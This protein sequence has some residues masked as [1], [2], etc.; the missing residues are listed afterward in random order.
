MPTS[1]IL[2]R[3]HKKKAQNKLN[4]KR[5]TRSEE[6]KLLTESLNATHLFNGSFVEVS[7][8]AIS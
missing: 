6:V 1:G 4:Q 8:L 5:F 3:S 7:L 2:K